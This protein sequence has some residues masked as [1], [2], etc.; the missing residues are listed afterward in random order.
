MA[1]KIPEVLADLPEDW[2][3]EQIIAP[4]GESVGLT[5]QHGYNYLMKKVNECARVLNLVSTGIGQIVPDG[6]VTANGGG[7]LIF[8]GNWGKGP[9]EVE[10]T[11]GNSLPE[12]ACAV[13][14]SVDPEGGGSVSGGGVYERGAS[15]TVRATPGEGYQF[16]GWKNSGGTIVNAIVD[17]TFIVTENV[18]LTA[19]FEDAVHDLIWNA[20]T[21]PS[22]GYWESIAYGNGTFV[23]MDHGTLFGEDTPSNGAAYSADGGRTWKNSTLPFETYHGDVSCGDGRFVVVGS[24][25]TAAYSDDGIVWKELPRVPLH[26]WSDISYGNGV[27]VAIMYGRDSSEAA[28][29]MDEGKTWTISTL[30]FSGDWKHIAF[31]NSIFVAVPLNGD[32]LAY[33][34][35]MGKTW[36][37]ATLPSSGDLSGIVYSEGKFI[38]KGSSNAVAYSDDGIMWNELPLSPAGAWAK[39]V[40]GDGKF[41]AVA[42]SNVKAT[43][44]VD[45]GR[46]WL[47][48]T[49]PSSTYW[50][51]VAYGDGVFVAVA[52]HSDQAA[53]ALA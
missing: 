28:Y 10:F 22:F 6:M 5:P 16:A 43:Y 34:I 14:L 4:D 8:P 2:G 27:F 46:T 17:Y 3:Y 53:Y 30:P 36:M 15:V 29:S 18:S 33:S 19:Q 26:T 23:A 35:D 40:Y 12:G 48:S 37:T 24:I 7:E 39:V 44:T 38:V 42:R 49:L 47:E 25:T 52:D 51:D 20:S 1:E 21:L 50:D 41:V 31:G 45:G 32:Q 13:T 9:Y 11:E